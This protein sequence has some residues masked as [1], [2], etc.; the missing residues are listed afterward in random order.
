L[1]GVAALIALILAGSWTGAAAAPR[2]STFTAPTWNHQISGPGAAFVYPWGMATATNG[3]I[4]VGDY[5]NYQLKEFTPSGALVSTIGSRGKGNGQFNQPFGVAVDP[6]DGSVYVADLNNHR[7]VKF[8]SSGH[9]LYTISPP[10]AYYLSYIAVDAQGDIYMVNSSPVIS[11]PSTVF[12]YDNQGNYVSRFSGTGTNCAAGDLG[13]LRGIAVGADGNLYIADSSNKCIQVFAPTGQFIR[14]FGSKTQLSGN[15]RGLAIDNQRNLVY[16]SDSTEQHVAVYST[17]GTYDGVIG[18][19]GAGVGQLGGPRGVTIG[20]DGTVYVADYTYWRVNAYSPWTTSGGGAFLYAFPDPPAPPSAGGLNG[21]VGVAVAPGTGDVYISDTF[22]HRVEQ[23][24]GSGTLENSWGSRLPTLNGPYSFDYPRGVAV[25]PRNGN[26]W[27]NDTRSGYIKEY[28]ADGTFLSEFGGFGKGASQF[29]FAIGIAVG[30]DGTLYIPDSSV[31]SLKAVDQSGNE[32]PGFPVS[33]GALQADPSKV[34][35]C[36]GVALDQAGN[37]YAASPN[38][39]VVRVFNSSGSLISTIGASAGMNAP[40]GVAI[41]G[42]TLYVTDEIK[43]QVDVFDLSGT[44]LGRWGGP[45]TAHGQFQRPMG[46]ATDAAGNIY[47]NDNLNNRI[48][49]FA[50]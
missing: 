16:V 25:D 30:P 2:T 11:Q 23:F 41:S 35:G 4:I 13:I 3:D 46:I 28:T 9:F 38:E 40:Y 39:H 36:T 18:T 21:A 43:D 32:R 50:P 49:V 33:C 48:E 34:N 44:F 31:A 12:R 29:Y 8:D 22:D 47:V 1:T 7:V 19:P 5:N 6:N 42:T 20:A 27:V 10:Y 26:V 24:T 17:S 15:L 45:G 14:S 37:I